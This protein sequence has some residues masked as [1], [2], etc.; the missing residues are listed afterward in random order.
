MQNGRELLS[1]HDEKLDELSISIRLRLLSPPPVSIIWLLLSADLCLNKFLPLPNTLQQFYAAHLD[2]TTDESFSEVSYGSWKKKVDY[3]SEIGGDTEK[4]SQNLS[5]ISLNH[6]E[7]TKP[8]LRPILGAGAGLLRQEQMAQDTFDTWT[9]KSN[10]TKRYDL[11]SWRQT[12]EEI[13]QESEPVFNP[14][15]LPPNMQN[16]DYPPPNFNYQE[17]DTNY[18]QQG[19]G[20]YIQSFNSTPN[21]NAPEF[22]PQYSAERPN[23]NP[24]RVNN[25]VQKTSSRRPVENWRREK[26]DL[27]EDSNKNKKNWTRQHSQD[28][29]NDENDKEEKFRSVSR[30]SRE[31]RQSNPRV[32]RRNSNDTDSKTPPRRHVTDVPRNQ[33]YWNHDDRCDKDY[34]S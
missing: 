10:L 16:Y 14:T 31:P 5:Q 9:T 7:D 26:S 18:L 12:E 34:N 6:D 17:N 28:N 22:V 3:R 24:E 25:E 19:D 29:L 4:V 8:K 1:I 32:N 23:V 20:A 11:N 15:V 27:K 13:K 30:S 33:K 2:L 21:Y